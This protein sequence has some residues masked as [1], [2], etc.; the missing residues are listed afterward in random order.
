MDSSLGRLGSFI[1]PLAIGLFIS[2]GWQVGDSFVALGTPALCAALFT[3]LIGSNP[4]RSAAEHDRIVTARA[5]D[6]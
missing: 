2:R 1:G 5:E 6:L 3:T 4:L